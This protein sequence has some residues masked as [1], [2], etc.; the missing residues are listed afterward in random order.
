MGQIVPDLVERYLEGLNRLADPVLRDIQRDGGE[1]GLPLVDAEVGALLRVLALAARAERILELGTA[2]G[3]SGIWLAGALP[4]QGMLVTMEIKE[5]RARE[6]RRNFSRA[7]LADR[8]HVIVG[9]AQRMLA[10]VSGPFDL[11][12]QDGD[13]R[14]YGPMLD[15]LVDLTEAFGAAR[16]RQ[17]IVE[18]RG[19]T[20]IH[21]G[22]ASRSRNEAGYRGLQRAHQQSSAVDDDDHPTARRRLRVRQAL[23]CTQAPRHPAPPAPGAFVTCARSYSTSSASTVIGHEGRSIGAI[24]SPRRCFVV[25]EYDPRSGTRCRRR[26][27]RSGLPPNTPARRTPR[28]VGRCLPGRTRSTKPRFRRR[29]RCRRGRHDARHRNPREA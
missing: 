2:I 14:Q 21:D 5:E 13:K 6:A 9:D 7:G 11:V 16:H 17:R 25:L 19:G 20:G 10:K 12:F 22:R 23:T 3:Y 18:R 4:P 26:D 24:D 1:R 8:V 28:N 27:W 29:G 15:R